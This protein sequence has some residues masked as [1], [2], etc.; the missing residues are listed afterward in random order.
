M[1][2]AEFR[3]HLGKAG[4]TINHFAAYLGVRPASVSNHSKSGVV[5]RNYAIIAVLL[6]DTADRGINARE[7]LGNFG[8][9][10]QSP[11]RSNSAAHIDVGSEMRGISKPFSKPGKDRGT[12]GGDG[13]TTACRDGSR[14]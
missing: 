12:Y 8:I 2:Y 6:G 5:P 3:R 9:F 10:P 13:S 1:L 7:L 4:M 14:A 11:R